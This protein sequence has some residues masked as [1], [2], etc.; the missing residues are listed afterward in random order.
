MSFDAR[1]I[2]L[3][4]AGQ[5][6]TS[7]EFPGLRLEAFTDRRTWTYR[8]RSPIDDKVRQ[9]KI[10]AWP[11]ISLH[12]A[13]AAWEGYRRQRD[14]G[15][16]PGLEA[17]EKK[18]EVR[19]KASAG[20]AKRLSGDFTVA[21]VADYYWEGHVLANRKPKGAAEIRRMFDT[22]LGEIGKVPAVDLTRAQ[23]FDLIRSHVDRP[24]MAGN[25]RGELGAAWDYALD[26][27]RLPEACPNWWR[28][29][30]RGKLKS[31]GKKVSGEHVG[32]AKRSL[33]AQEVGQL[34][35]WLPNFTQLV[36]DALT[37][38]LWTCTRGA[39]I[40][41]MEGREVGLEAGGQWWWVIPKAKTKNARHENATDLRVPLFGRALA[42]VA[43][44]KERYGD[45][46]LF[47]AKRRDGK[48]VPVEQKTIQ[49]TVWMHQPYSGTRPELIRPRLTVTNWA[50][51]DL[52]RSSRTL[53]A[54]MGCP[55]EVAESIL[56]HMLP[57]VE[58]VYNQHTYDA[59][60][61]EWLR[62]L[63]DRLQAL[64]DEIPAA[65]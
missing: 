13:I 3:L 55:K 60:R 63:S 59:E 14:V 6:L 5:H 56:G 39:E 23:A 45:G 49:S 18:A 48:I 30:L 22:M 34:I 16:D 65:S 12:A 8:Y 15:R 21:D 20:K 4:Q 52:R 35:R 62:R 11:A 61:V 32:T 37:M 9:I 28:L 53:L 38:Y 44:R 10:G 25:L 64:A 36:E 50:P 19:A 31:K 46:L 17:R 7:P 57:G 29:I 42:V 1:A 33:S 27:G 51:H 43:R 2:K 54:A 24:V 40:L 58:G 26:A 41:T 47:P